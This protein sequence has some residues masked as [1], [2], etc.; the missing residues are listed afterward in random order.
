MFPGQGSQKI[1]MGKDIY[2]AF[3]S[4][5]DVFHEVDDSISFKLS[6]II[7]HGTDNE[8]KATQNTQPALMA[9]SMAFVE[10]L[11]KEFDISLPQMAT[12]FAGHSLGEYTA[13]CANQVISISDAAKL[14]KI[15][16]CAMANACPTA[17]AMA[18]IIGL[19]L[20]TVEEIISEYNI[21]NGVVQI[22]TDNSIGQIVISG[23]KNLIQKA[24]EKASRANAKQ[25]VLLDVSG[26]F[27]SKL[28]ESAA[29]EISLTLE[30]TH[31]NNPIKPIISNV[32]AQAE[33][34]NFKK[35]L[36]RQIT[37]RIRWRESILFAELN[38]V[39]QCVEIG[40]GKVLVGLVKRISPTMKTISINSL[41][42]L[43]NFTKFFKT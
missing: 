19:N 6:D 16:G 30:K 15:R 21:N 22:A 11:K 37:E 7:F 43:E 20:E 39:S 12:F 4:A 28:M 32:T 3:K 18:A 42:S 9:V 27:H 10:V 35:L 40:S 38:S 1:G 41:E 36:M 5:K 25:T 31:F 17:G 13:L 14:L 2:D 33:T 8:L 34:S 29:T 26:P 24:I 23:H